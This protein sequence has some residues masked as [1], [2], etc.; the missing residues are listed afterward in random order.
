M[1]KANIKVEVKETNVMDENLDK[2]K[3]ISEDKADENCV[4]VINEYLDDVNI[5]SATKVARDTERDMTHELMHKQL[6]GSDINND[7]VVKGMHAHSK[8]DIIHT[9]EFILQM[10]H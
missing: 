3:E 10:V 2:I 5:E 1:V 7:D 9:E 6:L 4:N 8:F